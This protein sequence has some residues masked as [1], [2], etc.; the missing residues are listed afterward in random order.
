MRAQGM[1][2]QDIADTLTAE[3]EITLGGGKHWQP[4]SVRAATR[5]IN[6]EPTRRTPT[7]NGRRHDA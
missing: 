5:P 1:S 2:L 3:G 7:T 6:P 4:W